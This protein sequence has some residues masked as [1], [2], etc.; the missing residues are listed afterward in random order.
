M[1]IP[2]TIDIP[3]HIRE[4]LKLRAEALNGPMNPRPE[5]PTD[6]NPHDLAFS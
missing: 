2:T 5:F 1:A 6:E 4:A 3:E